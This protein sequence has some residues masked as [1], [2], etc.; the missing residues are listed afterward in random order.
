MTYIYDTEVFA[1]DFIVVLKNLETGEYTVIH[2][3]NDEVKSAFDN[4]SLYVGFNSKH[5]DTFIIKG[6]ASDFTPGEVKKLNDY[7]ISG[8]NQGWTY[9][10]LENC[11]FFFN[12]VDLMDDCQQGLSLKAIEAHIGMDIRE[13]S[14]DFNIQRPLTETEL[15]EVITYCKHDVDATE[16]LYYLRKTYLDNKV[17]IGKQKGL[18]E[19]K[20][21]SMTNAK[22]TAVW[23]DAQKTKAFDDERQYVYPD[24]L[25]R[26][27]IPDE[28]FMYFDRMYDP[29]ISD[30]ELYSEGYEFS[31][32]E[33]ECKIGYGGIHGA[34][35]HY[36]EKATSTRSIRNRDVSSYYPHLVTID[37]YVSRNIPDPKLYSDMLKERVAA[38]KAGDKVKANALKLVANTTYGAML[39]QY[40]DLYDPLM[41]RSVCITG[42]LRLVEL[43]YHLVNECKTLKIIQLNTDG[44]M[45]SLDNEDVEKYDEI[46]VFL[47]VPNR[48]PSLYNLFDLVELIEGFEGGEVV[49]IDA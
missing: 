35:P 28:I 43:A 12:N 24:N 20:S 17:I 2:N 38:K 4:E 39:N 10:P 25:L 21:L 42:Q 32:G 14:V 44:I 23:L 29:A 49:D 34:I 47:A 37:G 19:A 11:K 36:R 5:Y 16:K 22:L 40:N 18:S 27:Y 9:Q 13:S 46:A 33:C 15:E 3:D 6:I 45:V 48:L 7:I 41:G 26:D 30:E 31:I 1:Y 8:G